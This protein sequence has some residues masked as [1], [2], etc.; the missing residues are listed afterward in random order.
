MNTLFGLYGGFTVYIHHYRSRCSWKHWQNHYLWWLVR[1]FC[2]YIK[3]GSHTQASARGVE[4]VSHLKPNTVLCHGD[5]LHQDTTGEEGG[6]STGQTWRGS[7]S[8]TSCCTKCAVVPSHR[9]SERLRL[10]SGSVNREREIT[11]FRWLPLIVLGS[12][13]VAC[14]FQLV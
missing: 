14:R 13:A 7:S 3:R 5:L 4:L 11:F 12:L 10:T 9:L 6:R 1:N 8:S 2:E